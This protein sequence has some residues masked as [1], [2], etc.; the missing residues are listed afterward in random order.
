ML[1]SSDFE[2]IKQII[3]FDNHQWLLGQGAAKQIKGVSFLAKW[4]FWDFIC[5]NIF[6]SWNGYVPLTPVVYYPPNATQQEMYAVADYY[7]SFLEKQ[8]AG[9]LFFCFNYAFSKFYRFQ[10]HFDATI[11]LIQNYPA[12]LNDDFFIEKSKELAERFG[13][14]G[15]ERMQIFHDYFKSLNQKY[16]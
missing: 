10:C 9:L 1:N 13:E 11:K 5:Q 12:K 4:D 14:P 8:S 16:Q 2:Q 15:G 3:S 7:S 6:K